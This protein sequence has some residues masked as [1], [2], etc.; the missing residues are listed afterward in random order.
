MLLLRVVHAVSQNPEVV[1]NF[2][3]RWKEG[4]GKNVSFEG[5]NLFLHFQFVVFGL[6][7]IRVC[8]LPESIPV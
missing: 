6:L 3:R 1:G 4:G 2:V 5:R 8:D 7:P